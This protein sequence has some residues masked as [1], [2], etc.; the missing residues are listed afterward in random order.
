MSLPSMYNESRQSLVQL[1]AFPIVGTAAFVTHF[2]VV[3]IA[4]PLGLY[5]L[6]ANV[7]GFLCAFSVSFVGHDR[8]SFPANGMRQ[9]PTALRRF[10]VV[11]I[12][13]FAVN[14]TAYWLLLRFTEL[15]YRF[16]L[17]IV[18]MAVAAGTFVCSKYWAF[19]HDRP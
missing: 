13:G 3:S 15:D 9:R 5:P 2:T 12:A 7:V 11:A 18:L 6:I 1:T 16:A 17:I 10:L 8:F 4:A 14:E 19:G